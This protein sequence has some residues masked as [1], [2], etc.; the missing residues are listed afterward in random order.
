MSTDYGYTSMVT[1]TSPWLWPPESSALTCG[2]MVNRPVALA[3]NVI[4]VVLPGT[5]F[6]SIS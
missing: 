2:A 3:V 4:S 6:F 1:S 5:S